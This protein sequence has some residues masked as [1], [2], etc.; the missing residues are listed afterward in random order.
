MKLLRLFLA[1][2][3]LALTLV[4]CEK[5]GL[6][7]KATITGH[8][9]HHDTPIPNATVYIKY[10]ARELPGTDPSDFDAQTVAS[11]GDGHYEF[12]D[13]QKG[14]YYLFSIGFDSTISE[15]VKGG[16]PVNIN[17]KSE[18][19]EVNIPVTE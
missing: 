9:K 5:E 7:G 1:T 19:L 18:T 3:V 14:D 16:I 6:G 15:A 2:L 17:K 10:G 12:T 13:L 4:A 11:S 8:V